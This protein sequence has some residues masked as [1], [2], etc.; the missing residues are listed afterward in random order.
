MGNH[1][2]NVSELFTQLGLP[3]DA[4]GVQGFLATHA[5]LAANIRL[6]DAPFWTPAQAALL[7]EKFLEDANWEHAVDELNLLLRAA[8]GTGV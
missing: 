3:A 1:V 2:H 4:Q 8:P 6:S 5:P 7:Q